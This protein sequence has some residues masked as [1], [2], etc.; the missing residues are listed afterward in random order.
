M[1]WTSIW[2]FHSKVF[3]GVLV[4][5][6]RQ[7]HFST[8]LNAH[9][10]IW[11][12]DMEALSPPHTKIWRQYT[13]YTDFRVF[14]IF[15]HF[16]REFSFAA[17]AVAVLLTN[18][19]SRSLYSWL[20]LKIYCFTCH[21]LFT[22][23]SDIFELFT[24][25]QYSNYLDN[26]I[27]YLKRKKRGGKIQDCQETVKFSDY[28][29]AYIE[30]ILKWLYDT[31]THT[32]AS[33]FYGIASI[34]LDLIAFTQNNVFSYLILEFDVQASILEFSNGAYNG[35]AN[36]RNCIHPQNR[37]STH[38]HTHVHLCFIHDRFV[39]SNSIFRAQI[40]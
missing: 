17:V 6:F 9:I 29:L 14:D 33:Q 15:L 8:Y 32:H 20:F 21:N 37:K 11:Y 2:G 25:L 39:S 12:G 5:Q 27:K 18:I 7:W 30:I 22:I 38:T 3:D 19:F 28:L 40:L 4:F 26:E 31:H 23:I 13:N 1:Y 34:P 24:C 10:S 36:S 16:I 35:D